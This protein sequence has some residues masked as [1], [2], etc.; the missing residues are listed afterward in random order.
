MRPSVDAAMR[1]WPCGSLLGLLPVVRR[2][3]TRVMRMGR[4]VRG[5]ASILP[6]SDL[7]PGHTL[8]VSWD[9][10]GGAIQTRLFW[11]VQG[12]V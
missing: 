6:S 2:E 4:V 12:G 11:Q 5:G 10:R 7:H 8:E 3:F 1:I 9:G